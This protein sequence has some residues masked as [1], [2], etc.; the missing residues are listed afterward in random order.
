M[1]ACDA[2]KESVFQYIQ[3]ETEVIPTQKA[4]IVSLPIKVL[5]GAYAEVFIEEVNNGALLVHDGGKTI[6]H[7]ESSGL[8]VNENRLG[9]LGD[10]AQRLGVSLDDGIFKAIAKP[11]TVQMFALAIGQCCSMALFEL[12]RHVPFSEEEQIRAKV[13]NEVEH[14]GAS[15]GIQVESGVKIAGS[16]RQYKI[17]FVAHA[18]TP[19]EVSIL[20]PSYGAKVSADR[21]ALQILDLRLREHKAKNLAVLAKPERW[22][23]PA[24]T[25]VKRLADEIAEISLA[26]SL[27]PSGITAALDSLA[28]AA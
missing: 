18:K 15:A 8:L 2:I 5:D 16:V 10:L 20:I 17:D 22:S 28:H 4:C 13:S 14:W 25:V 27:L 12:L 1:I 3:A 6:G 23:K 9:V 24:R 26:D 7:L 19:V 21:Y 11:N